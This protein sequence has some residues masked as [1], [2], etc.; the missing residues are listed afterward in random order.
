[1]NLKMPPEVNTLLKILA[2]ID[3]N[4]LR[5]ATALEDKND[6]SKKEN[7]KGEK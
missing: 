4:L 7:E 5:I 1:M 3:K 2:S 6:I